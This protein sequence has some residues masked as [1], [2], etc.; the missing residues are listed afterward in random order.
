MLKIMWQLLRTAM[1]VRQLLALGLFAELRIT[2]GARGLESRLFVEHHG[3][4]SIMGLDAAKG[5]VEAMKRIELADAF[6]EV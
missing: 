1:V 3:V 5:L 2:R 6:E 4:L